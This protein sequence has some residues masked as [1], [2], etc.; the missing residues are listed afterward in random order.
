[1]KLYSF[2][3]KIS[4]RMVS[5]KVEANLKVPMVCC[6]SS[7]NSYRKATLNNVEGMKAL[8]MHH[9]AN[10]PGKHVLIEVCC[11]SNSRF[12]RDPLRPPQVEVIRITLEV[13]FSWRSTATGLTIA[14]S[15]IRG[16][17]RKPAELT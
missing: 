4:K 1:M 10:V 8:P 9:R 2:R 7:S 13:D 6:E 14:L 17:A 12:G 5:P 15:K 11:G 16:A 3:T